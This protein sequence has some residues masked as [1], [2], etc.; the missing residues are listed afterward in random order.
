[1]EAGE[2]IKNFEEFIKGYY[3]A[4]LM[5]VARKGETSVVLDFVELASFNPELSDALLENPEEVLKAADIAITNIDLP[6]ETK[7]IKARMSNL[8]EDQKV[9][10]RNIRAKHIDKFVV[11][12]GTVRQKSD[13]RPQVTSAKFECPSC[14]NVINVLQLDQKFKEPNRCGCGRKGKFKL[15]DKELIDAQG[16]FLEEASKDLEGGEQPKRMKVLLKGDLVTPMSE[17]KTNPGSNVRIIGMVKEIPIILRTGGQSTKYD[18]MIEANYVEGMEED[19]TN[20]EITQEDEEEIKEIAK[21]KNVLKKLATSLAPGIYGHDRIKEAIVLQF[22]GG[23]RKLSKDGVTSRGDIHILLVGDPGAGKSQLLKRASVVA[24]KSR[25]VSGKGTSGAGLTASVVKDEF[26]SGWSLEAGALV[27]A[28]RGILMVDELDKMEKEDRSSMHEGLEQQ[29]IS[30]SKANIQATL[31]CETTVLAAANPKFGRFD[32][33]ETIDKQIDLPP[34]LINRFD[35][36]FTIKDLPDEDTDKKLAGFILSKHK[37]T[38][39]EEGSKEEDETLVNTDLLRKYFVY[40]RQRLKPVLSN[41]AI[42]ELQN[43]YVKMRSPGTDDVAS[44]KSVPITARQLEALVRLAE[45]S[46]KVRLSNKVE[47]KDA[48][49][50]ISLLQYCLEQVGLD[51]DTGKIDI[52]RITTGVTTSE[53]SK[54]MV[55]KE[56]INSLEEKEGKTISIESVVSEG[57]NKGLSEDD[58]EETIEKLKRSGDLFEPK[59]GYISKI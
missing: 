8:P 51:P 23:S 18:L 35:L 1:M 22:C 30:I 55:V 19:Y 58:I 14:G 43:Y 57:E 7:N 41:E 29:T 36:I 4:D 54:I 10:V 47:K 44:I 28:N 11:V 45:S 12:E 50:A 3:Y 33:Y 9:L 42:R 52:D 31:R 13:V 26:L 15:L 16:M 34:T 53:R 5:E 24:P 46:A 25:Y 2:Q 17:K 40:C 59:R 21:E 27:L 20:I 32:P 56:I 37:E 38:M 39:D 48:K 49:N 6:N